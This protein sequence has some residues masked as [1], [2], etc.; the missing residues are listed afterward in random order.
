VFRPGV[1]VALAEIFPEAAEQRC[2]NH[3]IMNVLGRLPKKVQAE[4]RTLLLAIPYAEGRAQAKQRKD[5]FVHRF[6]Q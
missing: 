3:K 5:A 4:A 2:W 1:W 6:G